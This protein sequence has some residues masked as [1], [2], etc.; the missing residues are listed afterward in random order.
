MTSF[1]PYIQILRPLNL[2][3]CIIS[4]LVSAWLI[5]AFTSS[6][7]PYT[8]IVVFCFTGAANIL[9]DVLDVHIDIINKP[10]RI[11]PSGY[12]SIRNAVIFMGLLFLIGILASTQ[13]NPFGRQI[14]LILVLP[15]LVLYTPL[16][17]R[18]PLIGN[19]IVGIILGLVFLFTEGS[20]Y[21]EIN[22]M[23]TPFILATILSTIRELC[24]DAEDVRG[25]LHANFQT[26]P[27]K[28]GFIYTLWVI[29]I[30]SVGLCV[31]SIIPWIVGQYGLAYLFSLIICVETPLLY[32]VFC[33]IKMNSHPEDYSQVARLMKI[34][35]L[36]GIIVIFLSG[37]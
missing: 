20:I 8:I 31:Y 13:I 6:L 37:F 2:I 4:V 3:L 7:L 17:K 19:L 28:Y 5:N 21:G 16:F 29:R 9:N 12:L 33:I 36:M 35:T 32:G 34:V 10:K 15:M 25:D 27:L 22:M 30:L 1:F 11:L 26:F 18:L 23:W 14:A 24:K